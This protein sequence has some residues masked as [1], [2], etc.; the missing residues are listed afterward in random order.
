MKN[1]DPPVVIEQFFDLPP[2][3]IWKAITERNQMVIWFF[4]N[5]PDFRAEVGFETR[6]N[7]HNEGRDFLHLWKI[8]EVIPNEKI[9]YDWSYEQYDGRATVTFEL[10]PEGNRT[11][12][13]LTNIV[14][15]DFDDS[16]PEFKRESCQSGWEFFI[17]QR[18]KDYLR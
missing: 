2:E 1:S 8:T 13:R 10:E 4:E 16:I 5:I 14:V 3:T 9:T 18:L 7:I 15:A 11:R 12:L 17:E 6:F